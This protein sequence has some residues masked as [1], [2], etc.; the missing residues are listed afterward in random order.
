LISFLSFLSHRGKLKVFNLQRVAAIAGG[1]LNSLNHERL[2]EIFQDRIHQ[3][4]RSTLIPPL[5][6]CLTLPCVDGLCGIFL[7]GSGPCVA[8][9]ASHDADR[10][11]NL[12]CE[13][14]QTY[15]IPSQYKLLQVERKGAKYL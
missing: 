3:P 1:A 9:F 12:I 14:F 8:A 15:N 5:Q 6:K 2:G 11:G 10:I 4:Y 7:S 13:I